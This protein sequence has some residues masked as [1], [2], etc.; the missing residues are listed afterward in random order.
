M[1]LTMNENEKIPVCTEDECSHPDVVASVAD[2]MPDNA[3]QQGFL[4]NRIRF[5]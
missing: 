2:K 4:W 1:Y 5:C 3:G